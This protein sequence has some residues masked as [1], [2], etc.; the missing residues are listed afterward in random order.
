MIF[1]N[2]LDNP[3][4]KLPWRWWLPASR[5]NS[6]FLPCHS[7]VYVTYRTDYGKD[8]AFNNQIV[9]LMHALQQIVDFDQQPTLVLADM[10]NWR[11]RHSD[12]RAA[13]RSW[14]CV[15]STPSTGMR[16]VVLN[17]ADVYLAGQ[18]LSGE[19]FMRR[20]LTQLLLRPSRVILKAVREIRA[21]APE[22]Y[23]GV[24]VR[25]LS[26]LFHSKKNTDCLRGHHRYSSV[27]YR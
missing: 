14:A 19:A 18:S 12:W 7:S 25:D 23:I 8:G 11:L 26:K 10:F 15:A 13:F 16:R 5:H 22:G 24:H 21:L 3:P 1:W 2:A 6:S 17:P 9:S 4:V 20:A 27:Q